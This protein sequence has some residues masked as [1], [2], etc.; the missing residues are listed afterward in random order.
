[1]INKGIVSYYLTDC[2]RVAFGTDVSIYRSPSFDAFEFVFT[3]GRKVVISS[4]KVY[5][6]AEG[7]ISRSEFTDA[8]R[9]ELSWGPNEILKDIL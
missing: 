8:I 9:R 4:N 7:K 6:L 5:A 2:I 3:N 1:M